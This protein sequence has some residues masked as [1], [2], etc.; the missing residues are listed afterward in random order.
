MATLIQA[1]CFMFLLGMVC[2][3]PFPIIFERR[4]PVTYFHS[5]VE[6]GASPLSSSSILDEMNKM[7]TAMHERFDK[8]FHS[9]TYPFDNAVDADADADADDNNDYDLS[10]NEDQLESID[11][12]ILNEQKVHVI[13]DLNEIRKK[14]D[15]VEPVCTTITNTPTTISPRKSRRKKLPATHTTTCIREFIYNG[16]THMSEETDTTD[17]KGVLI[18]HTKTYDIMSIDGDQ[19]R[20]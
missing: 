6:E 20:Q 10:G 4:L 2:S 16:Q 5:S 12:V 8:L 3:W 18:K 15:A 17:D 11:K 7:M 9:P 19:I 13:D 1:T 14:L